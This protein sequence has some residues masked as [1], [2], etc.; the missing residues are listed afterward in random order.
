MKHLPMTD[1]VMEELQAINTAAWGRLNGRRFTREHAR[2]TA[3]LVGELL[4]YGRYGREGGC[5]SIC[6]HGPG[7]Q[8]KAPCELEPNH[9]G[10][11][12]GDILGSRVAWESLTCHAGYSYE[13]LLDP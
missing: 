7:H 3:Y 5:P 9:E 1:Q 13:N 11:H 8:S 12:E 4:H 6:Y 2:R 10:P